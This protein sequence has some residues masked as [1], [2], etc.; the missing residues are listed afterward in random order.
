MKHKTAQ[1]LHLIAAAVFFV[2]AVVALFA[3]S[4]F[5]ALL[6]ALF[7]ADSLVYRRRSAQIHDLTAENERLRKTLAAH[8][9]AP[10]N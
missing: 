2:V 3:G 7:G 1:T 4:W 5:G 10:L 6:G 8:H 9:S